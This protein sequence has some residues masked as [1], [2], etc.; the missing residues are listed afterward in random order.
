MKKNKN[1]LDDTQVKELQNKLNDI[2]MTS[3]TYTTSGTGQ[4]WNTTGPI[5]QVP[6]QQPNW[7]QPNINP[8][9]Q[10]PWTTTNTQGIFVSRQEFDDLKNLLEKIK[11]VLETLGIQ[12]ETPN[13]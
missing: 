2:L 3:N 12:L 11:T 8:F 13:T 9:P 7:I 5:W 4:Q 10:T 6:Q 1:E